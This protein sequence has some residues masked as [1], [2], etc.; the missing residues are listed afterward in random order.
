MGFHVDQ[1][2]GISVAV[3]GLAYMTTSEPPAVDFVL[4][5]GLFV[6][7]VQRI[8]GTSE[9][10]AAGADTIWQADFAPLFFLPKCIDTKDALG[11]DV[12][13][14]YV[15][16]VEYEVEKDFSDLL[17]AALRNSIAFYCEDAKKGCKDIKLKGSSNIGFSTELKRS[18]RLGLPS[19][20]S[21]STDSKADHSCVVFGNEVA[22]AQRIDEATAAVELKLSNTSCINY[23]EREED[24][25]LKSHH[26]A[27][28]QA[29]TYTMDA[30]HC[31]ARRGWSVD[32]LAT[33]V[34]AARRRGHDNFTDFLCCME[35]TLVIP[36]NIGGLFGYRVGRCVRFS[37][38]EATGESNSSYKEAIAI[39][40]KTMRIGLERAF[41]VQ[42]RMNNNAVAVKPLL[43]PATRRFEAP[44]QPHSSCSASE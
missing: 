24:P 35:G 43:L 11:Q 18:G 15:E 22:G 23:T 17:F 32:S 29:L 21:A 20:Y 38:D 9:P 44:G 36:H 8:T 1:S 2:T 27:L 13:L 40:I 30:W 4:E 19:S 3:S 31:L 12:V 14:N 16:E 10:N 26:G 6:A 37:S 33:A 5:W 39:Y 7:Q 25:D 34:L 41:D 42:T 28:G